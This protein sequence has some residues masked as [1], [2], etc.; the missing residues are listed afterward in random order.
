MEDESGF[1]SGINFQRACPDSWQGIKAV[2]FLSASDIV[3][4]KV[5]EEEPVDDPRRGSR[6]A[7]HKQVDQPSALPTPGGS[8]TPI[9]EEPDSAT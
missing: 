2:Q 4:N 1:I 5:N 6:P 9:T 7:D 8:L 3:L